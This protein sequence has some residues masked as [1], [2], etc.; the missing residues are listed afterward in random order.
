MSSEL[1]LNLLGLSTHDI[2]K[3]DSICD[4]YH[5]SSDWLLFV[6]VQHSIS[7]S[8]F[9]NL[10]RSLVKKDNLIFL[11]VSIMQ[12]KSSSLVYLG[13]NTTSVHDL[14]SIQGYES[15]TSSS[16]EFTD[17]VYDHSSVSVISSFLPLFLH[18]LYL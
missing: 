2:P 13:S 14:G 1:E 10:E 18:T 7:L 8:T 5:L 6:A 16:T 12:G 15:Y 9:I 17:S 4:L 3:I 11:L